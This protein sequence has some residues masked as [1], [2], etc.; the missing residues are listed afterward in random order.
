VI[1]LNQNKLLKIVHFFICGLISLFF[2][3]GFFHLSF[4]LSS[5]YFFVFFILTTL[6]YFNIRYFLRLFMLQYKFKMFN[7]FFSIFVF[8]LSVVLVF[9]LINFDQNKN[10]VEKEKFIVNKKQV[11]SVALKPVNLKTNEISGQNVYVQNLKDYYP[12]IM[13]FISE[14]KISNNKV[15]IVLNTDS[16]NINDDS[17]NPYDDILWNIFS[18]VSSESCGNYLYSKNYNKCKE[19]PENIN[20]LNKSGKVVYDFNKYLENR[21]Y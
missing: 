17:K 11:V 2:V 3:A 21:V 19:H 4:L 6:I 18:N 16:K 1:V 13:Q 5:I 10:E 8:T 12:E 15:N 9:S 7:G 20:I 14:V